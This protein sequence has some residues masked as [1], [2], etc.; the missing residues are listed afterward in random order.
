MILIASK[1]YT[2]AYSMRMPGCAC[3][4]RTHSKKICRQ[5]SDCLEAFID[6]FPNDLATS[7]QP[8]IQWHLAQIHR[9]VDLTPAQR[10]FAINWLKHVLSSKDVDWIV[11][12][13]AMD[14]LAQFAKDDSVPVGDIVPLLKIQQNHKSSAIIKRAQKLLTELS[15]Q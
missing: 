4:P 15:V 13:N 12:A 1:S 14:T 2:A 5:H 6:R 11:A 9:E 3:A 7:T 8:S 10:R